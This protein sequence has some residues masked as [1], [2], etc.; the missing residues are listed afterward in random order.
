GGGGGG[1]GGLAG[2]AGGGAEDTTVE[3]GLLGQYEIGRLLGEGSFGLVYEARPV[4]S[5]QRVALK[6]IS[7]LGVRR[8]EILQEMTTL[9][10]IHAA[11]GHDNI[12]RVLDVFEDSTFYFFV[13]ELV[14]GG[15][16][17][18]H[19][20][21]NGPYS[22]AKAAAFMRELAAALQFLH[23]QE[24]I[25]ADLKPENLML[26]SWDLGESKLKVVDFGSSMRTGTA[27][28]LDESTLGTTWYLPP[29]AMVLDEEPLPNDGGGSGSG[30]QQGHEL[31]VTPALDMWAVGCILFIMLCGTHP[32]DL[33][34]NSEEEEV[35]KRVRSGVVPLLELGSG[36]SDSAKDLISRRV[37]A[38]VYERLTAEEM[39][40]H[41]WIQGRTAPQR[42]LK[43][44]DA[45]LARFREVLSQK[46]ET[47]VVSL[48][49]EGAVAEGNSR[50]Q[51]TY[52]PYG[53]YM[54]NNSNSRNSSSSS[55]GDAEGSRGVVEAVDVVKNAYRAFDRRGT[56]RISA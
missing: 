5:D 30:Q 14:S 33:D 27:I 31:L 43:G 55:T 49:V 20:T 1:G 2:G 17:F 42:P 44:S 51:Y 46:L 40:Q 10:A 25:H 6:Q 39:M 29:E 11:G 56:G 32:F 7:K 41:P 35:I 34:S 52:N 38:T 50:D 4:G 19:L 37:P 26:S 16:M 45:R 24:I 28:D 13:L 8:E 54:E 36:V 15:E 53:G 12:A 48:L 18:E 23:S 22:E 3:G 21:R 47:G 9:K